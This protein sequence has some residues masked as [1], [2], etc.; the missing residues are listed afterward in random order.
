[1]ISL[2]A[3]DRCRLA[4][5]WTAVYCLNLIVPFNFG[6]GLTAEA[7]HPGIYLGITVYWTAG[8]FL[9]AAYPKQAHALIRG[10]TATAFFQIAPFLQ[11]FSGW[12]ALYI[13]ASL[14]EL[15]R[16]F[17]AFLLV[18]ITGGILLVVAYLVGLAWTDLLNDPRKKVANVADLDAEL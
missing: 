9:C 16:A 13:V 4:A 14:G 8:L 15:D 3:N 1:M 12:I 11:F 7:G 10:G 17:S 18:L 5:A 6:K 2:I